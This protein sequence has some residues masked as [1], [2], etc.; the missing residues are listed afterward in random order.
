MNIIYGIANGRI[1]IPNSLES[2][3]FLNATKNTQAN[4][5]IADNKN[6]PAPVDIL[7]IGFSIL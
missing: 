3:G 2:A 6:K 1:K 4:T 5:A 7:R